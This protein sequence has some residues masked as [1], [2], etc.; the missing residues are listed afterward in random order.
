MDK[1]ML[2]TWEVAWP[3][4]HLHFQSLASI[5]VTACVV[6]ILCHWRDIRYSDTKKQIPTSLGG[7]VP[8]L[9]S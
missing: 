7:G 9:Y 1:E 3:W 4:Q 2:E 5:T 8:L 6:A